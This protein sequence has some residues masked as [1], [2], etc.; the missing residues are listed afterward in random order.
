MCLVQPIKERQKRKAKKKSKRNT[1]KKKAKNS[2]APRKPFHSPKSAAEPG[3]QM[4]SKSSV[5]DEKK[6]VKGPKPVKQAACKF[7]EL[8][9]YATTK[10][11]LF[12]T[13][14]MICCLA[15]GLCMPMFSYVFGEMTDSFSPTSTKQ[16]VLDQASKQAL[17][18][19]IIGVCSFIFS[20]VQQTTWIITGERQ[21]IRF[22]KEYFKAIINQ[23]IGWFDQINPNELATKVAT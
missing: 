15:N 14:G 8:L 5:Q 1:K 2:L 10:D 12:M 9:R 22:R 17:Y 21:A 18:L 4:S 20:F 3:T 11:K 13:I 23:E 6:K 19:T 7:S 16:D